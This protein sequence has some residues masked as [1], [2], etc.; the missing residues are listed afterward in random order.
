MALTDLFIICPQG[1]LGK[2]GGGGKGVDSSSPIVHYMTGRCHAGKKREGKKFITLLFF[3]RR[4][5]GNLR[6][7]KGRKEKGA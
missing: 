7:R 5:A 2:E 3:F 1:A 4:R 6:G